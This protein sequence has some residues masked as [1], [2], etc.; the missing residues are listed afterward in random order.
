MTSR[1]ALGW[2]SA[3]IALGA[4]LL[5]RATEVIPTGVA[6]WPW[7]LL[8]AGTV[9]LLVS[10]GGGMSG[11][12]VVAVVLVVVGAMFAMRDLGWLPSGIGVGPVLLI[13][14]GIAFLAGGL[15]R[16]GEPPVESASLPL[17]GA[18]RA[19]ITL[20]YG[21]G[22]LTLGGGA[23]GSSLYDGRFTGGVRVE[24]RRAGEVLEADLRQPDA[25]W[26]FGW[27][28]P[29]DWQISLS[30]AIPID[31]QL[32]TG[33]SRV[34]LDLTS[35]RLSSLRVSS[36]AS[37][38]EIRLPKA[39]RPKVRIEAGAADVSLVVPTGVAA[40]IRT[41]SALA[42]VTIDRSRFPRIDGGYRSPDYEAAEHRVDIELKGGVASFGVS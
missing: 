39:G 37:D 22:T 26:R 19:A 3:L 25:V 18:G 12:V 20:S 23:G 5:L 27:S 33:A 35:T 42:N 30:D 31:L 8:A 11:D 34:R 9:L 14:V 41:E 21:A 1:S 6:A 28:R 16:R 29:L 38:L 40:A 7:A 36:G 32:R 24:R 15:T 2:G 13:V 10:L 4:V 17:E